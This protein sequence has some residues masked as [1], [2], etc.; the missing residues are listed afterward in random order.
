MHARE[1]EIWQTKKKFTNI[2]LFPKIEKP[3]YL[4]S[5]YEF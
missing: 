2:V 3:K 4:I 5:E 1:R